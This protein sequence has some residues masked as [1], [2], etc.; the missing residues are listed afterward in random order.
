MRKTEDRARTGCL[1][2]ILND[3]SC[4]ASS[5]AN[6]MD[7][8]AEQRAPKHTNKQT[9]IAEATGDVCCARHRQTG[10]IV[11]LKTRDA[12]KIFAYSIQSPISLRSLLA[13]QGLSQSVL[14][15]RK[16]STDAKQIDSGF[17]F[18]LLF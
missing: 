2:L 13:K 18:E 5:E 15:L 1:C 16:E 3:V 12:N 10:Q 17:I 11:R 8:G 6:G 9:R 14:G 7:L 4:P